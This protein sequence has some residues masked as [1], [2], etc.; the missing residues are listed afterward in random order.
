MRDKGLLIYA[1]ILKDAYSS[2]LLENLGFIR[3]RFNPSDPLSK[4]IAD[5]IL[6]HNLLQ[7]DKLIM[8]SPS[9]PSTMSL[10]QPHS[11]LPL[12]ERRSNCPCFL[13]SMPSE[14]ALYLSL[15]PDAAF[16]M[17]ARRATAIYLLKKDFVRLLRMILFGH[18][19]PPLET[20]PHLSS[21]LS[22]AGVGKR[23]SLARSRKFVRPP[24]PPPPQQGASAR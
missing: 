1:G 17:C 3:T 7:N 19:V 12:G 22:A 13:N 6:L 10:S 24:V 14:R 15:Q 16:F 8:T 11:M 21:P 9:S 5:E 23:R 20:L 2:G 18:D 4:D